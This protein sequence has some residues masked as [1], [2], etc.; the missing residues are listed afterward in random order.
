MT[1]MAVMG[2]GA[3]GSYIGAFFSKQGYDIVLIDMW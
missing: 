1:K 2:V 3:V